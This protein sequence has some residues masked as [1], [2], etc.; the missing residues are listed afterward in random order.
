MKRFAKTAIYVI[1][2]ALA[3]SSYA[4]I[5]IKQFDSVKKPVVFA[6]TLGYTM[7][8]MTGYRIWKDSLP[9]NKELYLRGIVDGLD[10][11]GRASL[12]L[13]NQE[14]MDKTF[15]KFDSLRRLEQEKIAEQ[16]EAIR[17]KKGEELLI[18]GTKFLAENAKKPDVKITESGLQY[19]V[20][21]PGSGRTPMK[22][23]AAEVNFIGTLTDGSTFTDTYHPKDPTVKP[24]PAIVPIDR[25]PPGWAEG[26]MLMPIGSKYI[27]YIP[28]DLAYGEK[29]MSQYGRDII[30]PN[31]VL[32]MEV[33]MIAFHDKSQMMDLNQSNEANQPPANSPRKVI[34]TGPGGQGPK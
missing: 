32:I 26:M 29:G 18:Q 24:R 31:A 2:I 8:F 6:D 14:G 33:E 16:K 30:P 10:S 12:R 21:N 22:E 4:G 28:S 34:R 15:A 5:D 23:E 20:I 17:K 13:I 7:G 1:L 19:K 27:L 25:V 3:V 11:A 9:I